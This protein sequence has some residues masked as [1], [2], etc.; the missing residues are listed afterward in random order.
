MDMQIRKFVKRCKVQEKKEKL[1]ETKKMLLK[2]QSEMANLT[3]NY[4][5][6]KYVYMLDEYDNLRAE[7]NA[8]TGIEMGKLNVKMMSMGKELKKMEGNPK[9]IKYLELKRKYLELLAVV[10]EYAESINYDFRRCFYDY[11]IPKIFVF[12]GYIGENNEITT[13][14]NIILPD[15]IALYRKVTD[16]II[17]PIEDNNSNKSLRHFYNKVSFKYLEEMTNDYSFDLESKNLGKV[18]IRK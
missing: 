17:Y 18:K 5:V 16:T 13:A 7:K 15:T 11:N 8:V 6:G 2:L 1:I 3:L 12:Q 10:G 9:I 14:K 4:E